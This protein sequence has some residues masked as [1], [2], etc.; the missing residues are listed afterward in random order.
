[1]YFDLFYSELHDVFL[2]LRV[3]TL[4]IIEELIKPVTELKAM[5]NVLTKHI[6]ASGFTKTVDDLELDSP[7]RKYRTGLACI[8]YV[9]HSLSIYIPQSLFVI[10]HFKS[11]PN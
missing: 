4:K 1:M 6:Q 7:Y 2:L 10:T 8:Y 5:P 9:I 3:L 11:R